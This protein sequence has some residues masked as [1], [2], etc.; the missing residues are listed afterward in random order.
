MSSGIR[1]TKKFDKWKFRA[2]HAASMGMQAPE[3]ADSGDVFD[4]NSFSS[5]SASKPKKSNKNIIQQK[6]KKMKYESS[7]SSDSDDRS[8][9]PPR[10]KH[11]EKKKK[12]YQMNTTKRRFIKSRLEKRK[13]EPE[14]HDQLDN[15]TGEMR[16]VPSIG[17]KH[18]IPASKLPSPSI[19]P[20]DQTKLF[21]KRIE[22]LVELCRLRNK[23]LGL[24]ES[25][26]SLEGEASP[27]DWLRDDTSR[28][29][30]MM[31]DVPGVQSLI[32]QFLSIP[33]VQKQDASA[34]D[35]AIP[36]VIIDSHVISMVSILYVGEDIFVAFSISQ[37]GE[38][39][40]LLHYKLALDKMA[41]ETAQ[42]YYSMDNATFN[43]QGNLLKSMKSEAN[44]IKK[45][46]SYKVPGCTVVL[47]N[48][49]IA[50]KTYYVRLCGMTLMKEELFLKTCELIRPANVSIE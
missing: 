18:T 38:I 39:L 14:S 4:Y 49:S 19:R 24:L 30:A 44:G 29:Q 8:P 1:G 31:E 50:L 22:R 2:S 41:P 10:H 15:D 21:T 13:S 46:I 6:S 20:G 25:E 43:N 5:S 34:I 26:A 28:E 47:T 17:A 12:D 3:D 37:K 48:T 7:S 45:E 36:Q 11:K 23:H 16:E 33:P 42:T 32:N 27:K 40:L 9:S 35:S